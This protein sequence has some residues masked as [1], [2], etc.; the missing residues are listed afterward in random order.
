LGSAARIAQ[1][2]IRKRGNGWSRLSQGGL[3]GTM[4]A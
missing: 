1:Y 3:R 4:L 2:V